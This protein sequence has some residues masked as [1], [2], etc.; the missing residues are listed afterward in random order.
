MSF[1]YC[2]NQTFDV[3][4]NLINYCL[5][6]CT[7]NTMYCDCITTNNNYIQLCTKNYANVNY[8]LIGFCVFIF[9]IIMCYCAKFKIHSQLYTRN[10][11]QNNIDQL[12]KYYEINNTEN[13]QLLLN[14]LPPYTYQQSIQ[15]NQQPIQQNQQ[16]IQ[17]SIQSNQPNQPIQQPNQPIQQPIQYNQPNE[18]VNL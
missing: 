17:Q 10:N 2:I 7:T 18:N 8:I 5:S 12:P 3:C 15:Q 9:S 4:T 13:T 6:I 1:T 11:I 14:Q 16:S